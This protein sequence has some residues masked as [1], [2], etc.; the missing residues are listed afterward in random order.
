VQKD[1]DVIEIFELFEYAITLYDPQTGQG[2]LFVE[3]IDTF[4]KLKAESSGYLDWYRVPEDE[5]RYIANCFA[6]EGVCLDK[7][8]IRP[9]AEKRSLAKLFLNSIW[10]KQTDSYNRTNSKMISDPVELYRFLAIPGIEFA[11]L[12]NASDDVD[13]ASWRF[14]TEEKILSLR[15]TK[16]FL[17]AYLTAEDRLHLY[18]YLDRFQKRPYIVTQITSCSASRER[19]RRSTKPGHSRGH[20]FGTETP[21]IY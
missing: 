8:A 9:N 3:C 15:H 1:C 21:R 17:G 10:G 7:E 18:S 6:N 12:T 2:G 4:F 19:N 20:D 16:D 5:G 14:M 13:L 11:K